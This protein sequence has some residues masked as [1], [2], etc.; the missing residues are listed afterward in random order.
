[1]A[2]KVAGLLFK[3]SADT[4]ALRQGFKQTQTATQKLTKTVKV[5]GATMI[6]AFAGAMVMRGFRNMAQIVKDFEQ[7]MADVKAVTRATGSE[8]E[9][10]E[11]LAKKLGGSTKFTASE[12]A[13][14][15]KEYAKLGFTV[16]EIEKAAEATLD[17][18]AATG[19]D[20]ARAAEVAG[21]I[22]RAFQLDASETQRVTDVMASSFTNTALDMEKF[23]E[24]MKYVAP[25]AASA[26]ISLEES[27]ALIGILANNM[28]SGSQAG[29]SLR[30][31]INELS[32]DG[33]PLRDRLRELADTG[34]G[35]AD[36]EDEVGQRAQTALLVLTKQLGMLPR[37]TTEYENAAGAAKEMAEVQLDTLEGQLEILKSAYQGL[38]IEL[39]GST[40]SMD[41]AK[42][43][44]GGMATAL[45]WLQGNLDKVR[46]GL[47][48]YLGALIPVYGQMKLF[49]ALFGAEPGA[50]VG[51]GFYR[52]KAP[53]PGFMQKPPIGGGTSKG[54]SK[55]YTPHP[56]PG[57]K[58]GTAPT[59]SFTYG[60]FKPAAIIPGELK[61]MPP[62]LDEIQ[63]AWKRLGAT[64]RE[65]WR[66]M[67]YGFQE[68]ANLMVHAMDI[69]K[70]AM[71][72]LR[73]QLVEGFVQILLSADKFGTFKNV[74]HGLL[75]T[76][77]SIA[78]QLGRLAIGIGIGIAG[79]KKALLSLSPGAAI[80]AGFALLALAGAAKAAMGRL[81]S[82]NPGGGGGG[83][84]YGSFS[85]VTAGGGGGGGMT[86]VDGRYLSIA[87]DRGAKFRS[88]LT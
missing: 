21:G 50:G 72:E 84:S 49:Q 33:R 7:S 67:G 1:M 29:T 34:L 68:W 20:L 5:L 62:L 16:S 22:I 85:G 53:G 51:P 63:L 59:P 69:M 70:G 18:A 41:D 83:V 66:D 61:N 28:I 45:T 86:R 48:S 11:D 76:I 42:R 36:A 73:A 81:G 79:I 64:V 40:T 38:I 44:V 24:A 55:G 2:D 13:Q 4:K 27:T 56:L 65:E 9:R 12:V 14:L 25:V 87:V 71:V 74:L 77:A 52:K 32:K 19:T 15:E 75:G 60:Q 8:F 57:Q 30:K 54:T 80:G 43:A 6:T 35:L 23:A 88:A 26:N 47:T 10:L 37:L 39:E 3:I 31:I 17:L 82:W 58:L 46:I 78:G